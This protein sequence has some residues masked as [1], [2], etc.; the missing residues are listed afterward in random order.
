MQVIGRLETKVCGDW[1]EINSSDNISSNH[2]RQ[3]LIFSDFKAQNSAE[4]ML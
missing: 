4:D 3:F 1:R 2:I